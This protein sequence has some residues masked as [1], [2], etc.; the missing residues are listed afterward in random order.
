MNNMKLVFDDKEI[1]IKLEDNIFTR[2]L[3]KDL[4][5]TL[6]FDDYSRAEKI[7][8]MNKKYRING[9]SD[10][11]CPE[12]GDLMFYVPWG[13][14]ALFYNDFITSKDYVR[15]GKVISGLMHLDYLRGI[16]RLE[17]VI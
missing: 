16:V 2:E 3:I 8:Y 1:L 12:K 4:P 17:K 10:L 6:S 7:A 5:I 9:K 13:Y 11:C 14:L 15:I